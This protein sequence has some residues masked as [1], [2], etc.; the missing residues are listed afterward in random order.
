MFK[1][2]KTS[3]IGYI[4]FGLG[5][6]YVIFSVLIGGEKALK[7]EPDLRNQ[8]SMI[9]PFPGT[10]Q[11]DSDYIVKEGLVDLDWFYRSSVPFDEVFKHYTDELEKNGWKFHMKQKN[12]DGTV[13][14]Y[15]RQGDYFANITFLD[16]YHFQF[17]LRWA[18]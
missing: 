5:L 18:M 12:R 10:E 14:Y 11:Y 2:V 3:T 4:L 8:F 13:S 7:I 16:N 15:F 17:N 1:E 9:T 6:I